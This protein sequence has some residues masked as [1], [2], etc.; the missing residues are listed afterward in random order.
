MLDS[1]FVENW[2]I[3]AA[4]AVIYL[5]TSK[6]FADNTAK[7]EKATKGPN[8]TANTDPTKIV[9]ENIRNRRSFFPKNYVPEESVSDE[10]IWK[11]LEAANWAPTHGKTEPWRFVVIERTEIGKFLD[12]VKLAMETIE[13]AEAREKKIAKLEKKG[14]ESFLCL[15][16]DLFSERK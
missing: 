15:P 4:V 3:A 9:W 10:K 11:I 14:D 2:F 1:W 12:A 7:D 6:I 5:F 16:L 13:P 8:P